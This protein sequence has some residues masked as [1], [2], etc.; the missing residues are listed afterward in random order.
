MRRTRQGEGQKRKEKDSGV[1]VP[2]VR[3]WK[4]LDSLLFVLELV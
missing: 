3:V 2:N 1:L 4:I